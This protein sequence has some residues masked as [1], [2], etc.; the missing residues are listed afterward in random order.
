[1]AQAAIDRREA[2]PAAPYVSFSPRLA[3]ILCIVGGLLAIAGGLGAWV[4]V[5]SVTV[6]GS[7]RTSF[8]SGTGEGW[9]WIIAGVGGIVLACTSLRGARGRLLLEAASIAAV[10]LLALRIAA[11]SSLASRMAFRAAASAGRSFTAYHAGFGWGAW[12]MTLAA[13]LLSLGVVVG[14]LR[15]ID[16][17]Q[18]FAS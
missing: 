13:V 12:A 7:V 15:W 9:G 6:L 1:M 5:A 14:A 3:P 16:E 18:G 2:P 8:L 4:Q 11:V 17:R 10:V